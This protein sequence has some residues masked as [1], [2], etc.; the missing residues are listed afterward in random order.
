MLG[1]GLSH[2]GLTAI[3]SG[4][5][6]VNWDPRPSSENQIVWTIPGN[7]GMGGIIGMHYF[8][9][10]RWPVSFFAF[11]QLPD[12]V[13]NHLVQSLYKPISLWVVG[14]GLQSF[15]SKDL[16]HFLNHTT[17]E[18]STSIAQE[19]GQGPK[20]RDVTSV[21]KFSNVFCHLIGGYI[22][23]HVL[24]EM[25]LEHKDIGK[26]RGLIWLQHG[27]NAC[28]INMQEIQGSSSPNGV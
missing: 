11:S 5:V 27:L 26:S 19:P 25:I 1:G 10:M 13:H 20:D 16:A 2:V 23:Q 15:Y 3:N 9:Q 22:C 17:C 6:K 12:H 28:E 4:E 8:S 7:C 18:A 21:Q 14:H 24:H